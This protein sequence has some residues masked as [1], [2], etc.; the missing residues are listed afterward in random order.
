MLSCNALN[1]GTA[2][3]FA[4]SFA[5]ALYKWAQGAISSPI[6]TLSLFSGAGGL[7]IAFHD[8]GFQ[9]GTMVEIEERFVASL[10]ANCGEGMYLGNADG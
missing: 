9:I 3:P 10:K 8:A 2:R 4:D 7:D 1:V 6:R 5:A